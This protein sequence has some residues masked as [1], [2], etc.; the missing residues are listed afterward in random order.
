MVFLLEEG[1]TSWFDD[2]VYDSRAAEADEWPGER[3]E[4]RRMSAENNV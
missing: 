3:G 4:D 2:L 1:A